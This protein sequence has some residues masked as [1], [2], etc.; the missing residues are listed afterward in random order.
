MLD[1]PGEWIEYDIFVSIHRKIAALQ[2]II[3]KDK[4]LELDLG[5]IEHF[6]AENIPRETFVIT[7]EVYE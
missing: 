6:I 4:Q 1:H 3:N 5:M 7:T 2:P